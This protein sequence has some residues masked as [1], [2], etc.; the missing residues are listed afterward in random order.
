MADFKAGARNKQ[1]IYF[2][3]SESREMIK[4]KKNTSETTKKILQI[5]Q[6]RL[7]W[8]KNSSSMNYK[9]WNKYQLYSID[10]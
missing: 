3:M 4:L 7:I 8:A 9:V 6:A 1:E 2:G 10:N 5:N